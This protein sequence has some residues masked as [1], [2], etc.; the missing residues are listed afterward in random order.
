MNSRNVLLPACATLLA[1]FLISSPGVAQETQDADRH[2]E[3]ASMRQ[4]WLGVPLALSVEGLTKDNTD[5]VTRSLTSLTE[6]VYICSSCKHVAA[7][8]GK[9]T[10]C[11][12]ELEL[13]KQPILSAVVPSLKEESIRLTPFAA[14]TLSYSALE[15]ALAR[16]SIQIDDA[17]FALAGESRLV[18][19]GGVLADVRPIEEALEA[20][21]LFRSAK[22]SYDDVSNEIHVV[23]HASAIPP[24]HEKVAAAIEALDTKAK[25]ADV[26]WGPQP[27]P[28]KA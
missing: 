24:M 1:G 18:L 13:E 3:N 25:L 10:S 9:C 28:A 23:V 2:V 12:V 27:V 19:R 16:N 5:K 21:G 22:A 14:R 17:K 11:N 15:V 20:A 8:A 7:T 4:V 26:V 6:T